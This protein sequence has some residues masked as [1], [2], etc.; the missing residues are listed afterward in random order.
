MPLH[1]VL[2]AGGWA[3]LPVT[4]DGAL[5]ANTG[6]TWVG[7]I[8]PHLSVRPLSALVKAAWEGHARRPFMQSKCKMLS[9]IQVKEEIAPSQVRQ[10]SCKMGCEQAA[11]GQALR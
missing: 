6:H 1:R 5:T 8:L 11:K 4:P 9:F 3:V 2:A 7:R 10:H